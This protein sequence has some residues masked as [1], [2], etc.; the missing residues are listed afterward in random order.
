[1]KTLP[2]A[3]AAA[4][5]LSSAAGAE[6]PPF[7]A[8]EAAAHFPQDAAAID[9]APKEHPASYAD[10]LQRITPSVVSVFPAR[11]AKPGEV[12]EDE[13]LKR[14]F[15]TKKSGD[16]EEEDRFH[17]VGSGVIISAD[18]YIL[19]NSHVVHLGSGKL[20]DEIVV[21]FSNKWRVPAKIIGADAKAD[22]AVLK[23]EGKDLPALPVADSAQV[24]VGD[25][26]FA[27]GN[28]FKV[29]ITAT[30][31]MVS[32]THRTGIKLT[33]ADGYE[34]FIQTDAAIN[35]GNSGG[36]LC[37]A[38]GRLIGINTAI[39]GG[40]GGNVGIGFAVTSNLARR[41]LFNLLE[42]GEPVRG[43]AGVRVKSVDDAAARAQ[44]LA[45]VRGAVVEEV[46]DGGPGAKA[47][48]KKGDV[49]LRVGGEEI[50]G[51]NAFRIATAF[52]APGA[53]LALQL[54]RDGQPV[55]VL[56]T[57]AKQEDAATP[58]TTMEI[59]S[60]P[61]V[62]LREQGGDAGLLVEQVAADSAFAKQL[63]AGMVILEINDAKTATRAAAA[64]ALQPG[65][66]KVRVQRDELTETLSLR[67]K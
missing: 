12:P 42:N 34:D 49:V 39:V 67:V 63:A 16:D 17:S 57:V 40:F 19:T 20:A 51:A 32:A 5:V 8:G 52:A 37:D 23:I 21:E 60:L 48:L 47:G 18:G 53:K 22:I 38:R 9:R 58:G 50:D 25:L 45:A 13:L 4:L 1:M 24:E 59:E 66:N 64:A 3:V 41:V 28:P 15:G 26:V 55:E 10:V 30:M 2:L 29:G 65:P 62:R 56:L 11:L 61:G 43:F 36:A 44:K 46:L 33:G 27:V 14:F 35:P 7:N 31:G 6:K 54:V